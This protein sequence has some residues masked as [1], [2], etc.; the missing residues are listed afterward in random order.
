MK[1]KASA[2]GIRP[3]R[4][5]DAEGRAGG[6]DAALFGREWRRFHPRS[7]AVW[8]VR[9]SRVQVRSREAAPV[10]VTSTDEDRRGAE[11]TWTLREGEEDHV[12][13]EEGS[14]RRAK[15]GVVA[16]VQDEKSKEILQS[17]TSVGTH[18]RTD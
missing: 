16:F 7:C 17:V 2:A 1:V 13:R 18:G 9:G 6:R 12:L 15:L 4:R 10:E 14:D 8:V 5:S 11:S 3:N